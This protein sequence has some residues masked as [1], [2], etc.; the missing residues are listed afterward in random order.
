M[1]TFGL[2][3]AGTD[4]PYQTFEGDVLVQNAE[5]V[6]VLDKERD[7]VVAIRLNLGQYVKKLERAATRGY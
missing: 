3:S 7:V 6:Q 1:A 4:Q 5:Y 2:F